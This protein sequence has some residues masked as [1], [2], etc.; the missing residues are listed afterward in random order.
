M[1][2]WADEAIEHVTMLLER[3]KAGANINE[4]YLGIDELLVPSADAHADWGADAG[5]SKGKLADAGEGDEVPLQVLYIAGQDH[6]GE[7][8]CDWP[9][10]PAWN[11]E[12]CYI[13]CVAVDEHSALYGGVES[14]GDQDGGE[15]E[16]DGGV[17][18]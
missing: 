9:V 18:S 14:E 2:A 11:A 5:G 1:L 10:G 3:D 8:D 7:Q 16:D 13:P 12:D 17:E 4:L 6:F 15:R